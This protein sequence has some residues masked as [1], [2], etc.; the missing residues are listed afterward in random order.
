MRSSLGT[1]DGSGCSS[2]HQ[3]DDDAEDYFEPSLFAEYPPSSQ[4]PDDVNTAILTANLLLLY[5]NLSRLSSMPTNDAC[6]L[7]VTVNNRDER[8]NNDDNR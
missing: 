2:D 4:W 6:P 7:P 5:L 1:H 8:N 3:R